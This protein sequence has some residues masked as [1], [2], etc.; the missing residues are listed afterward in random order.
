MLALDRTSLDDWLRTETGGQIVLS[1]R[2]EEDSLPSVGMALDQLAQRMGAFQQSDPA[3]FRAWLLQPATQTHLR[4]L[5]GHLSE[6]RRIV[7]LSWLDET[8]GP[9][10]HAILSAL[11]D[12]AASPPGVGSMLRET[13]RRFHSRVE[14]GR[15]V[16]EARINRLLAICS[17]EEAV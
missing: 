7:L 6:G 13:L 2:I 15:I 9:D 5:L 16:S 17:E 4:T 3:V 12:G 8:A 11:L 10:R 14:L 1:S